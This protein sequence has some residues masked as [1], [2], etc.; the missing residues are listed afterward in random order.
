[1]RSLS[2]VETGASSALWSTALAASS[3]TKPRVSG[4]RRAGEHRL[5]TERL[6]VM[7]QGAAVVVDHGLDGDAE[8][9]AIGQDALVVVGNARR[10][11]VEIQ[12]RAAVPGDVLTGIDL[13][14]DIAGPQ[15]PVA[16]A[17]TRPGF[18]DR[19]GIAGFAQLMR[20]D[21]SGNSGADDDD[22]RA[23]ARSRRQR[24]RPGIGG[25]HRQQPHRR[26]GAIGRGGTAG[27]A[28]E[29]EEAAAREFG[30]HGGLYSST[31]ARLWRR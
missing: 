3:A 7:Q 5:A 26:H 18:E 11:G 10:A 30:C 14:D 16:P 9:P 29:I 15:R 6:V 28:D 13:V 27:L 21:H 2:S 19:A 31:Q 4:D 20:R 12:M 8:L 24:R 25:G 22:P 17:R 23:G 1:M